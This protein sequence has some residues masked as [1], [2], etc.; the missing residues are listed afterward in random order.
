M[1]SSEKLV[2]FQMVHFVILNALIL[3]F[4]DQK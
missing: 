4:I 3:S 1:G 2:R